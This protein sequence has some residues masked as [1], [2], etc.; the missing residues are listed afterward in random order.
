MGCENGGKL[1][2]GIYS[3]YPAQ[4]CAHSCPERYDERVWGDDFEIHPHRNGWKLDFTD[5]AHG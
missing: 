3:E 1:R 4:I 5:N 2:S